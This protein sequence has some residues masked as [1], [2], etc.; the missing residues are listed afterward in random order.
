M[1][2]LVLAVGAVM[3]ALSGC[4][5]GVFAPSGTGAAPGLGASSAAP[6]TYDITS[7]VTTVAINGG[8]GTI[9]VTGSSRS[10]I[11]VTEQAYYSVTNKRPTTSHV[12]SGTTLTLSYSCPAQLTCGVAYDVQVPRGL[13]VRV[14]D[15]EGAITLAS[16]AGPVQANTIAGVITAAGL[17]SP[18]ATLT[19]AAGSITA[20]FTAVPA[21]VTA[22]TNAGS[23]ALT[24]PD[25]AAYR[26][27]AHTY[28]GNSV[29]KVH[30]SDRSKS[31]ISASCDFGNV[32]ISP[33]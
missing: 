10:T 19:S 22:S 23:I 15:R 6:R 28:V 27:H 32:T 16:L 12:V 21:S 18:T 8:A 24:V 26:V 1:P 31:V 2:G 33:S 9:T 4:G 25:S 7:R 5:T 14:S 30:E 13:T 11:A 17:A 3:P 29:V 20:A